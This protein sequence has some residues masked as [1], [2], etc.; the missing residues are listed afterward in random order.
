LTHSAF[1][2]DLEV[3]TGVNRESSPCCHRSSTVAQYS[4]LHNGGSTMRPVRI[5]LGSI[6]LFAAEGMP[7]LAAA[8]SAEQPGEAAEAEHREALAPRTHAEERPFSFLLDPSTPS[9]GDLSVEYALGYASGTAA[10][11]PLPSTL[12]P[13]GAQHAL[14]FSYGLTN[15]IAPL[16]SIRFLQPTNGGGSVQ[17]TGT[18]GAVFLLTDPEGSRFRLAVATVLFREFESHAGAYARLAASYDFGKLRV[19]ANVHLERVFA[20][21]RDAVDVLGLAG[22]SYKLLDPLRVGIE[23]V[24]QDLEGMADD[25]EAEGGAHHYAG[26]TL[27]IDLLH[28]R[29]QLTASVA[30]GLGDQAQPLVGR[31]AALMTF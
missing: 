17:A 14:T 11:R 7:L 28:E 22:V 24:G 31:V 5:F 27:A 8:Q 19:A 20:D 21:E 15:R 18:I 4:R 13:T 1:E 16:A 23:Y 25:E 6:A 9:A 10:D 12:A 2:A 30:A 29:L 3:V 26:P